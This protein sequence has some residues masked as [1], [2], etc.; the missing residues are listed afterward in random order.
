[1]TFS[2]VLAKDSDKSSDANWLRTVLKSGTQ[3]DRVAAL[4]MMT[5]VCQTYATLVE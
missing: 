2:F 3:S 1:M 4:T 5:Q